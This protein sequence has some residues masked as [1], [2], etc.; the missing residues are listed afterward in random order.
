MSSALGSQ[1]K[2]PVGTDP[3]PSSNSLSRVSSVMA[4]TALKVGTW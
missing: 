1:S 4:P 3:G 2:S